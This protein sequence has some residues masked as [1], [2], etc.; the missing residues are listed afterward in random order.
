MK[1]DHEENSLYNQ[2]IIQY[3]HRAAQKGLYDILIHDYIKMEDQ[4]HSYTF[5]DLLQSSATLI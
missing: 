5:W 1:I 4:K 3:I 2:Q